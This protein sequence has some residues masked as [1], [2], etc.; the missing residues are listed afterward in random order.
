MKLNQLRRLANDTNG[1]NS[2]NGSKPINAT[3]GSNATNK[4]E[5]ESEKSFIFSILGGDDSPIL[6]SI[7]DAVESKKEE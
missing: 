4:T 2:T 3:N 7:G 5:G 6:S 1:S